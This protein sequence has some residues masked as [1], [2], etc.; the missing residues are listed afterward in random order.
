SHPGGGSANVILDVPQMDETYDVAST[1][2]ATPTCPNPPVR[3]HVR[4]TVQQRPPCPGSPGCGSALTNSVT[5]PDADLQG[6]VTY[7]FDQPAELEGHAG[8]QWG[9]DYLPVLAPQRPAKIA[10][11]SNR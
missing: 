11:V 8:T 4:V 10:F 9:V 2:T 3:A 6:S 1:Q 7:R 5:I